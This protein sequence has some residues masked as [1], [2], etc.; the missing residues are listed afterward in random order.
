MVE[1]HSGESRDDQRISERH[2]R[3]RQAV[4]RRLQNRKVQVVQENESCVPLRGDGAGHPEIGCVHRKDS[5]RFAETSGWGYTQFTSDRAPEI[6][7]G[8][9]PAIRPAR[10]ATKTI[11]IIFPVAGDPPGR[12]QGVGMESAGRA[13]RPTESA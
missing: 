4:S 5:K 11:P 1:D 7:A 9:T 3:Q 13:S 2:S 6:V 10:E 12:R 8:E